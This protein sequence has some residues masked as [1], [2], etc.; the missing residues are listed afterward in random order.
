MSLSQ[1]A[2]GE[3]TVNFTVGGYLADWTYE[4]TSGDRWIVDLDAIGPLTAPTG[5]TATP[6]VQAGA[7]DLRW[8]PPARAQYHF[9]AW[10]P[11]GIADLNQVSILPVSAEGT[12]TIFGL[13]VGVTYHFIVI[14]GR[15][16]WTP[17][18]GAKWSP[19]SRWVSATPSP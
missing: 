1:P 18:Y 8:S 7:V 15:W 5:L 4:W 3:Y 16:E 11:D 12:T 19:W 13:D 14:A 17:D 9:V 10:T 6:S 2:G